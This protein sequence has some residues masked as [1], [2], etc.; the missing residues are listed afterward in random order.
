[1]NYTKTIRAFCQQNGG[2]IFDSQQMARDYFSMIPYKTFMKI[3]N[4]LED[5]QLLSSVSKGVYMI[6]SKQ[7]PSEAE[8]ILRQYAEDYR[9]MLVGYAMY[10]A[11]AIS[12]YKDKR[13]EIY[14]NAIPKGSHKNI[15]HYHLTGVDIIFSERVKSLIRT[16]ELIEHRNSICEV[17]YLK[18]GKVC[19]EGL[20]IYSDALFDEVSKAI[21]YHYSTIVSLDL[22]LKDIG[23]EDALCI[24]IFQKND[25]GNEALLL[26]KQ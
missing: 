11:Y 4:R 10:N 26:S 24:D 9:G 25:I 16:L 23:K 5:E 2:R 1:M 3:L 8:A 6:Q 14:T 7:S 22:L 13:V 20:G 21:W 12:D 18:Y 15:N 19:A 17:D